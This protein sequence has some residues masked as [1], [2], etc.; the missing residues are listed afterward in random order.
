MNENQTHS[1]P[2][3]DTENDRFMRTRWRTVCLVLLLMLGQ[4]ALLH[5][6]VQHGLEHA[7]AHHENDG[8]CCFCAIGGHMAS[9]A[10]PPPLPMPSFIWA[11][12]A[13]LLSPAQFITTHCPQTLGARGPPLL[14]VA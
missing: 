6:V 12:V 4:A 3:C 13:L 10:P 5:H 8:V 9:N 2:P 14:S 1:S 11:R 7:T